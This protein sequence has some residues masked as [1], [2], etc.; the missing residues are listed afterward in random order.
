MSTIPK[1]NIITGNV[2]Q[3]ADVLNII[4][5][6]DASESTIQLLVPGPITFGTIAGVGTGQQYMGDIFITGLTGNSSTSNMLFNGTGVF[7]TLRVI[8]LTVTGMNVDNLTVTSLSAVSLSSTNLSASFSR[9]TNVIID[10]L[11]A[12]K[13]TFTSITAIELTTTGSLNIGGSLDVT[14][15]SVNTFIAKFNS[16]LSAVK[17][18]IA[19]PTGNVSSTGDWNIN[20]S[21]TITGSLSS[22]TLSSGISFLDSL[23]VNTNTTTNTLTATLA[24]IATFNS[25]VDNIAN[26][27]VTALTGTNVKFNSLTSNSISSFALTSISSSPQYLFT[28]DIDS[29]R[30]RGNVGLIANVT[31]T[32]LTGNAGHITTFDSQN[33]NLA[34]VTTTAITGTAGRLVTFDSQNSNLANVAIT[35]IT[36]NSA[37]FTNLTGVNLVSQIVNVANITITSITGNSGKLTNFDS[38]VSNIANITITAITGTAANLYTINS[39]KIIVDNTSFTSI[40]G[41]YAKFNSITSNSISSNAL[42]SIS[43]LFESLTASTLTI[44]GSIALTGYIQL[45]DSS[46]SATPSINTARIYTQDFNGYSQLKFVDD[47]GMINHFNEDNV[48]VVY[49]QA[50]GSIIKGTVICY[51]SPVSGSAIGAGWAQSSG[52]NTMPA[53]G[54]AIEAI[55]NGNFGRIMKSGRLENVNTSAFAVGDILYVDSVPGGLTNVVPQTSNIKQQVGIVLISGTANGVM[56]VDIKT[57]TQNDSGTRQNVFKI[58][59]LTNAAKSIMF[60]NSSSGLFSWNPQSTGR[61]ITLPDASGEVALTGS[62][63]NIAN[64]LT[65]TSITGTY[66]KFNSIT[67]NSISSF[68]FTGLSASI[69]SITAQTISALTSR[70]GDTQLYK[71]KSSDNTIVYSLSAGRMIFSDALDFGLGK[72][73]FYS[74]N[75]GQENGIVLQKGSGIQPRVAIFSGTSS[76]NAGY[77]TFGDNT[78]WKLHFGKQSDSGTTTWITLVDSGNVGIGT[79]NVNPTHKLYVN[80]TVS[81]NII[82]GQL[83]TYNSITSN[84]ITSLSGNI[85]SLSS[86][87]LTFSDNT[88]QT[89]AAKLNAL[90]GWD[91][92]ITSITANQGKFDSITSNSI[93]FDALTGLSASFNSLTTTQ[94]N[95]VLA[96]NSGNVGIGASPSANLHVFNSSGSAITRIE[97]LANGDGVL[98][99]HSKGIDTNNVGDIKFVNSGTTVAMI[100][101][102]VDNTINGGKLKFY[103]TENGIL[104]QAFSINRVGQVQFGSTQQAGDFYLFS[105][106][107]NY[108]GNFYVGNTSPFSFNI[109]ARDATNPIFFQTNNNKTRLSVW[110]HAVGI[111][112]TNADTGVDTPLV[113]FH[114]TGSAAFGTLT[115]N[116][117]IG[118]VNPIHRLF[119][120]GTMSA[121]NISSNSASINSISSN[122]LVFSDNSIQTTASG[123]WGGLYDNP[124]N[125]NTITIAT[126]GT[127]VGI[128]GL[129]ALPTSFTTT[130][131]AST[132][133]RI[134]IS[135]NG[136]GVYSGV[137]SMSF[138]GTSSSVVKGALYK[139]GVIQDQCGFRRK[140]GTPGDSGTIVMNALIELVAGDT[141]D[142]RLTSNGNGDVI[143]I[144]HLNFNI[145]RG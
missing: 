93:K 119:V 120:N 5:V 131:Q 64:N 116:V 36:G 126:A 143:N 117:G 19:E 67:A 4:N 31:M 125:I 42:T 47:T 59:D 7:N 65:V 98:E 18:V 27:T 95:V 134:T 87:I 71:V 129:S 57:M 6:L 142:C 136:N 130:L 90:T 108:S 76:P 52:P 113:N 127:F 16:S 103:T 41:T 43:G 61:V 34:N 54:I 14:G 138:S 56:Q 32:A 89:T 48:L 28:A 74:E 51:S 55:P 144:S 45:Q 69:D 78:G 46:L 101:T 29:T 58:G 102:S 39:N 72:F 1:S 12:N 81:A 63:N 133:D 66:A 10:N 70:F 73:Y 49:N 11:T 122:R 97:S 68:A 38:Q 115:G 2:V 109:V 99:F 33:S 83:L 105:G 128:S 91:I 94:G 140:L 82:T 53:I 20:G 79:N 3:A 137:F 107:N 75:G 135:T 44:P 24:N 62:A 141:L 92:T 13:I 118:A 121:L 110:Q 88:Q 84:S 77:I 106:S 96:Q 60:L 123:A 112:T 114:V 25:S 132:G 9:F 35:S 100:Q 80:G 23:L 26:I 145:I 85:Q 139:N 17:F 86:S 8:N 30:I 104:R 15:S 40:T 22:L 37:S 50:T 21:A 111:G 124:N